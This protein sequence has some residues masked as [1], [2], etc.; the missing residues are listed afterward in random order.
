MSHHALRSI[1][2][3][4]TATTLESTPPPDD[5]RQ[6]VFFAFSTAR[7]HRPDPI[8]MPFF[9]PGVLGVNSAQHLFFLCS[10][11]PATRE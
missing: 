9:P 5:K 1:P 4:T 11:A 2:L 6:T 3:P 7:F 8:L 10:S